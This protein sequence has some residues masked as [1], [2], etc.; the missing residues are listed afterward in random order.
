M[1]I[2]FCNGSVLVLQDY[3]NR[4][5]YYPHQT[6]VSAGIYFLLFWVALV[7]QSFLL[8][9]CVKRH[10]IHFSC[11]KLMLIICVLDICN[12]VNCALTR[13]V[14]SLFDV[15]HCNSGMWVAYYGH[16]VLFFWWAYCAANVILAINRLIEFLSKSW[17]NFFFQGYRTWLWVNLI[18]LYPTA[19][20]ALCPERFYF[21]DP[22]EGHWHFQFLDEEGRESLNYVLLYNNVTKICIILI[23]YSTLMLLLRKEL[24]LTGA[25][26]N[27]LQVK[28]SIQACILAAACVLGGMT[29]IV[30]AY[31]PVRNFPFNSF[32][33][34]IMW[35]SQH[36]AS[37]FVYA[38]INSQVKMTIRECRE[39]VSVK[40]KVSTVAV[41]VIPN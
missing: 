15:H 13:S 22:F 37:G 38:L 26:H 40:K 6:T 36:A 9:T 25:R 11:F 24:R 2:P 20:E 19:L 1:I 17:S 33:S 28:L 3:S 4:V 29:P 27:D 7:P 41:T 23:S 8:I 16:M 35:I 31:Y 21:F 30:M 18:L 14:L 10:L 32:L 39:K 12:L 34:N 5:N